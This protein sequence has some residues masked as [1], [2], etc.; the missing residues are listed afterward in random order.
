LAQEIIKLGVL[1]SSRADYGIYK[2]LLKRLSNDMRFDLHIIVFGTHLSEKFGYTASEIE[3]DNFGTILEVSSKPD[4]DSLIDISKGYGET[5][6]TFAEFWSKNSFDWVIALGDRFE[7][8]AAVQASI[9]FEV[10]L[11]HLH[12]GETTLGAVDNIYRHQIS[13]ASKLHFVSTE[14]FKRRIERLVDSDEHIYNVG[15]L[16]LD[17]LDELGLPSWSSVCQKFNIP[18]EPFVL[19]TFHP[20]TV[21]AQK[22]ELFADEAFKALEFIAKDIHIV[23]TM[24]NADAM[25][26]FFRNCINDLKATYPS[27]FSLVENFGRIN[28]FAAMSNCLFLLGNTS[29]GIVEAAS[30]NKYV[31]NVGDRQKG[32]LRNDNVIDIP[33]NSEAII[34]SSLEAQRLGKFK[35]INR[36]QQPD[37][38]INI[39]EVLASA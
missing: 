3:Q 18:N 36:F 10:K 38:A 4:T 15:A 37:T 17:D 11:A 29:S 34:K 26:S 28:Y 14:E 25:G 12:G 27:K 19:V 2:P 13:L 33:F 16:S 24:T 5:V 7:M 35:G 23:V 21:G 22:N 1:T 8:S 20:E 39:I 31:V 30:F 32:R 9:P 6:K